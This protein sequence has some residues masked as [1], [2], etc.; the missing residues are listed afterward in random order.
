MEPNKHLIN[1]YS[2]NSLSGYIFF[3]KFDQKYYLVSAHLKNLVQ[4]CEI[5][6]HKRK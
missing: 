3:I 1:H 4:C 6:N 2:F 5:Q